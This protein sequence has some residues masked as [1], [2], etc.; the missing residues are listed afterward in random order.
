[1]QVSDLRLGNGMQSLLV[2]LAAEIAR[3]ERFHHFAL[4]VLRKAL[5]NDRSRNFALA[6]AGDASQ[7]L[8]LLDDDFGLPGHFL[9]WDVDFNLAF[10]GVFN[11]SSGHSLD[12]KSWARQRQTP[13]GGGFKITNGRGAVLDT[14]GLRHPARVFLPAAGRARQGYLV[15]GPSPREPGLGWWGWSGAQALSLGGAK[16]LVQKVTMNKTGNAAI[17]AASKRLGPLAPR[18]KHKKPEIKRAVQFHKRP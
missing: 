9:S 1:M 3:D 8:K 12:Y 16:C 11:F 13:E 14:R 17:T 18:T 4:D 6:E 5:P 7:L 10:A 15:G 2:G